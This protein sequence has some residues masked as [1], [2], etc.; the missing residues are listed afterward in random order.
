MKPVVIADL[1]CGAGGTSTGAVE[2]IELLGQK[3]EKRGAA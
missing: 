1:F 3:A 2:A